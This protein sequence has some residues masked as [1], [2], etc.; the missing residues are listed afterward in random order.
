MPT[1]PERLKRMNMAASFC[2]FDKRLRSSGNGSIVW[3]ILNLGLG[4]LILANGGRWGAVSVLLG[5]ALVAAG[6]YERTVRDPKV[7]IVSAS[8]LAL[9]ALW[10]FTLIALAAMGYMRLALGGKTVYWAIAQAWGAYATWKTYSVYKTLRDETD[11][12]TVDQVRGYIDEVNKAKPAQSLDLVEFD[13]NAGFVQGTTRYRLKPMED[14]YMTSEYKVQ[15]GRMHLQAVAFV[16]RNAVALTPEGGKWMS[17][18]IKATIQLGPLALKKVTIT[19][20]M[21]ARINPAAAAIALGV[22]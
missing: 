10:N 4:G 13:T 7:I 1:D 22:T 18:K 2:L 17:K 16:P 21:A 5:L 6:A 19:P 14:L 15:L 20:D 12:V 9:L 8:T 11:P 3:G